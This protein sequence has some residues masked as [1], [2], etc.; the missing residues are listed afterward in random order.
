MAAAQTEDLHKTPLYD[1]HVNW[2][3][4]MVGFA[5]YAMPVQYKG[6]IAEHEQTRT[7]ASLFDVSHMGQVIVTGP[8]HETTARAL[9]TLMPGDLV[10]LNLG[11]MRY[12]LL[13]NDEGGIED[14]LI[15]TRPAEDGTDGVLMIV[16]NAGRKDHDVAILREKLDSSIK[17]ETFWDKALMAL[18]GP[19]AADVLAR[20]C[21]LPS[22]LSFMNAAATT[23]EGMDVYVSRSGYTGEDGFELSVSADDAV[24]L[25]ELLVSN[26]E[27]EPAG[28]GARDSLRLEAGLCL[29]GHDMDDKRDPI[30]AGLIFA[31]GK[32]RRVEGGFAGAPVV[33]KIIKDGAS[34]KRVGVKFEGRLPVREGAEIVDENGAKIGVVTSGT[35]G[36]TIGAPVAFA[37]VPKDKAALGTELTAMVRGKPV[38]GVVEKL[39]FTPANYVRL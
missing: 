11:E 1:T 35:F 27:V 9:E 25:A 34:E 30:S 19:K 36:P 32:G 6:V 17:I 18:Q 3:G 4:R 7:A 28:L 14:D 33:Q 20:Y 24:K 21:D 22:K 5:G 38:K 8:D 39:P 10:G 37:Y 13:L 23:I 12:T 2:G 31:I 29:Y 16:F 15:V 26:D